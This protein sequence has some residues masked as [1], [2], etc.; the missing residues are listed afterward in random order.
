LYSAKRVR[1]HRGCSWRL[2]ERL[3]TSLATPALSASTPQAVEP[4]FAQVGEELQSPS[5]PT[6]QL[7]GVWFYGYVA[8]KWE[9][10][11]DRLE[12]ECDELLACSLRSPGLI[13]AAPFDHLVCDQFGRSDLF[14][15]FMSF[16][17]HTHRRMDTPPSIG[18]ATHICL[19]RLPLWSPFPLSWTEGTILQFCRTTIDDS[20]N[21]Y[22]RSMAMEHGS[23]EA[24]LAFP[25]IIGCCT[26]PLNRAIDYVKKGWDLFVIIYYH[27]SKEIIRMAEASMILHFSITLPQHGCQ[28]VQLGG[29]GPRASWNNYPGPF[30]LYVAFKNPFDVRLLRR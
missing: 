3:P 23:N 5:G 1:E 7:L 15:R 29:D 19:D 25:F 4:P 14:A 12:R 22:R 10:M 8:E 2:G 28:N 13:A 27:F 9:R 21:V 17:F 18:A 26:N 30:V 6:S 16:T 24:N 11:P 20:I